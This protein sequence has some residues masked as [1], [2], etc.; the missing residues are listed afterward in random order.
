M[1]YREILSR[2]GFWVGEHEINDLILA[3][4][5]LLWQQQR[6]L[7]LTASPFK[8][9]TPATFTS[10]SGVVRMMRQVTPSRLMYVVDPDD[11]ADAILAFA[12]TDPKFGFAPAGTKVRVTGNAVEGFDEVQQARQVRID[13]GMVLDS[14]A[15]HD[16]L[17]W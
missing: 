12:N 1:L 10:V 6:G 3:P 11:Y 9:S 14:V 15:L 7:E 2:E 17:G 16:S 5:F 13:D 8:P 4:L